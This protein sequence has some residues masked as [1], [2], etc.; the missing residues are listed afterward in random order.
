MA[1]KTYLRHKGRDYTKT[2][3]GYK[4][5]KAPV[6]STIAQLPYGYTTKLITGQLYY[7][8][9]GTY[10]RYKPQTKR[11]QIVVLPGQEVLDDKL[12]F[13]CARYQT[14]A[15]LDTPCAY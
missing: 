5:V 14:I 15:A 2:K 11:Y 7:V 8:H 6:H 1:N 12:T 10:Y 9:S 4:V 13:V 3:R